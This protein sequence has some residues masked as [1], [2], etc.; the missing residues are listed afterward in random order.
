MQ[1]SESIDTQ[2]TTT[3]FI[4]LAK[5]ADERRDERGR[6][7]DKK[8]FDLSQQWSRAHS[9]MGYLLRQ[10]GRRYAACTLENYIPKGSEQQTVLEQ[11][12]DYALNSVKHISE[13]KNVVLYGP[14]GAGKDHLLM[15]LARAVAIQAGFAPYWVNGIELFSQM[16]DEACGR[17]F[18]QIL[19]DRDDYQ[20]TPLLYI[21]DPLPPTGVLSEFQ[22][23]GLYRIVDYRYSNLKPIWMTLNVSDGAEAE[24]RMGA[25]V[26]DRLRHDGLLLECNWPSFRES[27]DD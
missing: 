5:E 20:K 1:N 14:K 16:Q 21:S 23:A 7:V 27:Q 25:Q 10:R 17:G 18:R 6:W 22:Q 19:D 2:Y 8:D 26:V 9:M 11:L 3:P 15:G 4:Q 12:K 24:A 13:G